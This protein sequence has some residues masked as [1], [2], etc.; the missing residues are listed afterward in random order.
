MLGS[1]IQEEP[2]CCGLVGCCL[3]IVP[4]PAGG[5][6]NFKEPV[7]RFSSVFPAD[8]R[9]LFLETSLSIPYGRC[10]RHNR[11]RRPANGKRSWQD[12]T[13]I[14]WQIGGGKESHN[15][16]CSHSYRQEYFVQVR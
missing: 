5:K 2:C 9:V 10:G 3:L 15:G 13:L 12:R 11:S 4:I 14:Q 16:A 7:V 8:L 1:S 6:E